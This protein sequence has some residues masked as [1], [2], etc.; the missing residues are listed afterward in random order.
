MVKHVPVLLKEVVGS[1]Q[2]NLSRSPKSYIDG[3][4]GA[5][6]HFTLV[7]SQFPSIEFALGIDQDVNALNIAKDTVSRIIPERQHS[8]HL[9][10]ANHKNFGTVCEAMK[11]PL[12]SVDLMLFDL[13]VSSMQLDTA[14]RGFSFMHDAPL[15]MRMDQSSSRMSCTDL[16][17]R[18][19][20]ADLTKILQFYGEEKF[21]GHIAQEIKRARQQGELD[22]T[23]QLRE[24]CINVYQARTK[25]TKKGQASHG[26]QISP[27]TRT[28]Q[29]LR[30]AVNEELSSLESLLDDSS[31]ILKYGSIGARIGFISFHSLESRIL[32]RGIQN[33][34]AKGLVKSLSKKP[35][36]PTEE[37]VANN[38]RARSAQLRVFEIIQ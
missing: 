6:G 35:I 23:T 34:E 33:W 18:L 22:T 3:T 8:V 38:P 36:E 5:A 13:G 37:E 21:S 2:K 7:L 15:D 16:I 24:L 29:A 30:I 12:K 28:F 9:V 10:H 20:V 14:D 11:L 32:K 27:A 25:Q 26:K 4:V 17:D 31:P 19:S 1:F